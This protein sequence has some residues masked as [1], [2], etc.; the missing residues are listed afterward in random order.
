M[1]RKLTIVTGP[2]KAAKS[3]FLIEAYSARKDGGWPVIAFRPKQDTR[4]P[5]PFIRSRNSAGDIKIPATIVRASAEIL[6]LV[7]RD[8]AL[9]AIDEGQLFDDNLI[10]IVPQLLFHADV[11]VAGLDLD[12]RGLPFGPMGALMALASDVQ[13]HTATCD[14]CRRHDSRY[15]QRL[16]NGQP[17]SAF[18][19]TIVPE[20]EAKEIVYQT[21]C[22]KCFQPPADLADWLTRHSLPIPSLD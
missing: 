1:R 18:D 6:D 2:M 13:K 8:K 5:E 15:T 19:E 22:P 9:V 21:R 12:Y 4:D 16:V 3:L 11:V 20:G 10:N 14:V 17:A 7:T